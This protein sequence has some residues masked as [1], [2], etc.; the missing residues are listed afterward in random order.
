MA[1]DYAKC[2]KEIYENLGGKSNLVS[3]A[4][5][6]T[7]LRLV[8]V[9]NNK[10]DMKKL[11]SIDG[12]K[13][14]FSMIMGALYPLTVVCGI[15]HMYNVIGD[16]VGI[17][18]EVGEVV[19]PFDGE[20]SSVTET[21]HA[22]GITGPD[23]ME[24]LIHVGVDTVNMHGDGFEIFVSEGDKV[25]KGQKLIKFNISKIKAAGYSPTTAVLL[26]NS[27]D[28]PNFKILKVGKTE[29]MEKLFTV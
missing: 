25:T 27:D 14:V 20:I 13:G 11:E 2:A 15:H 24:V 16:G 12:V 23:G 8:T 1:M 19:A 21:H 9:D 28:Y 6:A 26:T 4:H 7:R 3:A 18:P 17:E 5:C 10:I 22:V 29:T